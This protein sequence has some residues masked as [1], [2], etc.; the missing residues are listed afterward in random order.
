MTIKLM[1]AA[2]IALAAGNT[3]RTIFVQRRR[4]DAL[5]RHMATALTTMVREIRWHHRPIPAILQQL[6][7]DE[8]VGEYFGEIAILLDSK[9]TLQSAW[10]KAFSEFPIE[11]ETLLN[12]SVAGDE[13]QLLASLENAAERLQRALEQRRSNRPEQTKLC[14]AAAM[15]AAGGLI[16]LLL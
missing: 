3:L 4:E 13:E 9:N 16:L 11:R 6:K 2:C 15:S 7:R 14:V 10:N 12:I 5:L 8:I 1:G